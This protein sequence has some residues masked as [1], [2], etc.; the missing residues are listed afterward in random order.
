[1][2]VMR[3]LS[4]AIAILAVILYWTLDNSIYYT[5]FLGAMVFVW[6]FSAHDEW[7]NGRKYSAGFFTIVALATVVMFLS[8]GI[9]NSIS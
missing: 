9:D 8:T 2:G 6:G 3:V 4:G 5:V 1:M 7:K